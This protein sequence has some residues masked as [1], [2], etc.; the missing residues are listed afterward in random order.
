VDIRA[1]KGTMD[2]L[3]PE[4]ESWRLLQE[5]GTS[6]FQ[7]YGYREIILPV[8]EYTEVFARG[9]GESTD[10]VQKEMFTFEDKGGRSLTLRPEATAGVARAF[11]QHHLETEGLPVKLYYQGPM[12]RHERPQAGRYRQFRQLGVELIGSPHPSAD[13]EVIILCQRF[14][15]SLDL[16]VELVINSVGDEQCRPDYVRALKEYLESQAKKL[17]EDCRRRID[18]NP[19]R[20]LD[21]KKEGCGRVVQSAPSLQDFLCRECREH[22]HEVEELLEASGLDFKRKERLVRGLDYYTR[23]VFEFLEP[24]LGA[25]NALAAGGR[26]DHLIAEFGGKPTPAVGFSIGLERVM[27]ANPQLQSRLEEGVYIL[28]IGDEARHKAFET[29]SGLRAA[30]IRADLDHLLRSPKA[31]MREAD[32]VGLPF[33]VIIG[34][35]ELSGGYYSL[36][37]MR[38]GT[39]DK[40]EETDILDELKR[41]LAEGR[42][43]GYSKSQ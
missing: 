28:A 42:Q 27:L 9:I 23:T 22:L 21:C 38:S 3:P 30:G 10:I 1:P 34:E 14:L 37:D 8:M 7:L 25:K 35:E 18:E 24:S 31:Q 15:A 17:C 33:C 43:E 16:D 20:V 41:R 39:Q 29:A 32:R 6:L 5:M 2:I 4:S 13:A 19:L 36:K 12:F 26:Y 40:V 11:V